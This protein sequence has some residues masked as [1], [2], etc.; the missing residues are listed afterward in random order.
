VG[1]Y[2]YRLDLSL[3]SA[4]KLGPRNN[5]LVWRGFY[6]YNRLTDDWAEFG[7]KNYK[8][9]FFSRVRSYGIGE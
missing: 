4:G 2:L 5:K 3:G 9:F 6:S 1:K 8:P 7:L